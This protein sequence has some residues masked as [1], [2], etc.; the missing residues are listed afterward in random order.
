MAQP[1]ALEASRPGKIGPPLDQVVKVRTL[2]PQP[3]EAP[4]NGALRFVPFL[5]ASP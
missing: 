2:A 1:C 5:L 3:R 4:Q